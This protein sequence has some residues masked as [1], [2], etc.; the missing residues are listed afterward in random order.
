MPGLNR[1]GHRFSMSMPAVSDQTLHGLLQPI[2]DLEQTDDAREYA[3]LQ[4]ALCEAVQHCKNIAEQHASGGPD[5][6]WDQGLRRPRRVEVAV[7]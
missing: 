1:E 6:P 2:P 3:L 5:G 4:A 7:P